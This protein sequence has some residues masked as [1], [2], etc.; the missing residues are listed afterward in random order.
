MHVANIGVVIM[1]RCRPGNRGFESLLKAFHYSS[2]QF[3][4]IEIALDI[5]KHWVRAEFQSVKVGALGRII[6]KLVRL[7]SAHIA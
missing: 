6:D 5:L 7:R 1:Q 3:V 2:G 4:H